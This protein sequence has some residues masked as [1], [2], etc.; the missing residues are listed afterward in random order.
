MAQVDAKAKEKDEIMKHVD[1]WRSEGQRAV[2]EISG[3]VILPPEG[4]DQRDQNQNIHN[5]E[6]G[7]SFQS[8]KA[9]RD[10]FKDL[11]AKDPKPAD[12]K[13]AVDRT[14]SREKRAKDRKPKVDRSRSGR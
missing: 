2:C 12:P 1:L 4:K 14:R 3:N 10:V 5:H 11:Q 7:K 8:W 13:P 6:E 9:A